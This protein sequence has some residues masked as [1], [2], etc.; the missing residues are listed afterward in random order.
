MDAL[1]Y[2]MVSER[3]EVNS[4]SIFFSICDGFCSKTAARF[5]I[6]RSDGL[7]SPRLPKLGTTAAK[8]TIRPFY[9]SYHSAG[10]ARMKT[11]SGC[12]RV[13]HYLPDNAATAAY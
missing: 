3:E 5:T 4:R 11:G 13:R 2:I 8:L 1:T 7:F 9:N 6:V 10:S 12:L